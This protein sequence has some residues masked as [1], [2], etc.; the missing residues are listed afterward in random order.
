MTP[1]QF[2]TTRRTG[3]LYT[4]L[5]DALCIMDNLTKEME[6]IADEV[7]EIRTM[8]QEQDRNNDN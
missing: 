4:R 5:L 3:E 1:E 7:M 6:K 2:N 8:L